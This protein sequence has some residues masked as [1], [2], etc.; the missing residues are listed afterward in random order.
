MLN[1]CPLLGMPSPTGASNCGRTRT[2]LRLPVDPNPVIQSAL[3]ASQNHPLI[4]FLD[5]GGLDGSLSSS[6]ER[7]AQGNGSGR[8]GSA[9]ISIC[10]RHLTSPPQ[11]GPRRTTI[12]LP[13]RGTA[14]NK[15]AS[16][17]PLSGARA[18]ITREG[19]LAAIDEFDAVDQ[20]RMDLR[21]GTAARQPEPLGTSEEWEGAKARRSARPR[22]V[23]PPTDQGIDAAVAAVDARTI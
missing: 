21:R 3:A 19:V 9:P 10:P 4:Q 17:L 1:G 7:A 15:A 2:A 23:D 11:A 5:F 6:G 14:R 12:P 16:E 13:E 22:L 8:T 18:E 20:R